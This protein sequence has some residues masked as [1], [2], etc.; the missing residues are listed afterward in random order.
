MRTQSIPVVPGYDIGAGQGVKASADPRITQQ[1]V[2]LQSSEADPAKD[3]QAIRTDAEVKGAWA[4]GPVPEVATEPLCTLEED[5]LRAS[6]STVGAAP[7]SPPR[8]RWPA[9]LPDLQPDAAI[10]SHALWRDGERRRRLRDEQ[11]GM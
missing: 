4:S 11:R 5:S 2:R 1:Q 6:V 10:A 9:L 8:E 7:L 3:A